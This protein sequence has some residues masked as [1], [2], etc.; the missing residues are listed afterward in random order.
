MLACGMVM[1]SLE[2]VQSA[3]TNTPPAGSPPWWYRFPT[4]I[5]DIG[6]PAALSNAVSWHARMVSGNFA[7]DPTWGAYGQLSSAHQA[8][9]L[10]E[11][12][13]SSHLRWISWV[14]AFGECMLY[15][16]G[17]ERLPDETWPRTAGQPALAQLSRSAWN[18]E[19]GRPGN[20]LRW[21]GLHNAL[22][23]EDFMQPQL[24]RTN[25]GWPV[26]TYPDGR[27]AIGWIDG[28]GYPLNAKVYDATGSKDIN[29]KLAVE[30]EGLPE[31][32]NRLDS[33]G[34]RLGSTNGLYAVTL[35]K[36]R[37]SQYPN[38]RPGDILYASVLNVGKDPAAPF[39]TNYVR[40]AAREIIRRGADGLWCDNFSPFNNFGMPSLHNAFGEWSEAR[41]RQFLR[42]RLSEPER[43]RLQIAEASRFDIRGALKQQAAAFAA[44]DTGDIHD[45]AW[46]DPRW[47]DVPIWNIYKVFKQ[48]VGQTALRG[49]YEAVKEEAA[50]AGRSD[51]LVAG[52]DMPIFGLGWAHDDWLDMVSTE[53]SPAW[54]VTTGSRGIMIPPYGKFAVVCRAAL[55]H[56]KGPFAT[57]WYYLRSPYDKY[58]GKPELAKVLAAEAFANGVF[59][60]YG[61]VWEYPGTPD[62]VAW[63][64]E[65]VTRSE[66]RFGSRRLAGDLGVVY[67]PDNQLFWV[68]PGSHALDHNRQPHSFEHWG[69]STMMVD[70]HL[71]YRVLPD[72]KLT[73]TEL[74][75][76]KTIYLPHVECLDD[77]PA[78]ALVNWVRDG[79]H[80]V[81]TGTTAMRHGPAGWFR[82]REGSALAELGQMEMHAAGKNAEQVGV[83]ALE[84]AGVDPT[85][86]IVRQSG[87]NAARTAAGGSSNVPPRII[88][89][90]FGQG[91]AIWLP[92]NLGMDYYLSDARSRFLEEQ[93]TSAM[94]ESILNPAQRRGG[95]D[96]QQ[97][98]SS[99]GTFLWNSTGGETLF[100]DLVNYQID[101]DRDVISPQHQLRFR[102][103]L[104]V[105]TASA[106]VET[107]SPDDIPLATIKVE[108]GWATVELR[109]LLHFASIKIICR[110]SV[111]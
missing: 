90:Q 49:F 66:P 103:R 11:Q 28:L 74:R 26:P 106:S 64:N 12:A 63:W 33:A 22:N 111:P 54:Y 8:T 108:D 50:K 5:G 84:L 76:F 85:R 24:T 1:L 51:F 62:S 46:R 10:F 107:I 110:K 98:P 87:T 100:T 59:L 6:T 61:D 7:A 52:N 102:M 57:M 65:F 83:A 35:E 89:R 40:V 82:K 34:N 3:E 78:R 68:V 99:V 15:A 91:M 37:A 58:I 18:W 55:A 69:L 42:E 79:G 39:W 70:R 105:G 73:A 47:L 30:F 48:H 32:V 71:S 67:S 92:S 23:D 75:S 20:A 86:V 81:M 29:G 27:S 104:P 43:A 25:L 16:A 109:T 94:V 80:L 38:R 96:P 72:W 88:T 14:E 21:V 95:F 93:P 44:K 101:P 97:L 19:S 60:K 41:F 36:S 2:G 9:R 13:K 56:Q 4:Y 45:P 31:K 17:F 53:F 77:A